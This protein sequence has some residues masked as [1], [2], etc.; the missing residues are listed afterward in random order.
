MTLALVRLLQS[1]F[2]LWGAQ[3]QRKG[4]PVYYLPLY[5]TMCLVEEANTRVPGIH[6]PE[7]VFD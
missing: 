6:L 4:K 2:V 5:M 7:V 1:H 3:G